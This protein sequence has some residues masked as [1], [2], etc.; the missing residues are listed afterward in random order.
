M[1]G[2]LELNYP[3][4]IPKNVSWQ[5]V[6]KEKAQILF[7]WVNQEALEREFIDQGIPF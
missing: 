3:G 5:D 6:F 4:E 2:S 7:N 1:A